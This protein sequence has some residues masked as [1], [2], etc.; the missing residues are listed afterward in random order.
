L[1]MRRYSMVMCV[2]LL[3][4]SLVAFCSPSVKCADWRQ[5]T[6]FTGQGTQQLDT[7]EFHINGSEWRIVWNYA[8]NYLEPSMTV[9]SFFIY[10]H[11]ET[12]P[13]ADY[14]YASG[15]GNTNGTLYVHEGPRPYY[16]KILTANTGGHTITVEYD[17][18][19][20]VGTGLLMAI[21][22]AVIAIP[23]II[24]IAV[25][26]VTRKKYRKQKP[27]VGAV[28]PPPPPPPPPT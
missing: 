5:V 4:F 20:E 1:I 2:L 9:F 23:A 17:K 13:M 10:R 3:A 7:Q 27:P 8:P 26:Y 16:L 18:D 12:S 25:V 28:Q 24:I 11:G 21:I 19:S 22:A 14:V 6:Q 15:A